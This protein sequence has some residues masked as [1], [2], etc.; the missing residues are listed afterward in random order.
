MI[1]PLIRLMRPGEW[2]KNGFVLPA[3]VVAL[4]TL[5]TDR[6]AVVGTHLSDLMLHTFLAFASFC[7]VSSGFYAI[8][9]V[10]DAASDRLHPV[11]KTR[12]VASG[13]V[14]PGVAL[15]FGIILIVA[16]FV[17]GAMVNRHLGMVL[18]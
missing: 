14:P 5:M 3:L 8:N 6:A 12:P 11:K 2:V 9:D 1:L 16:A 13:E 17:L 4:A 10:S 18:L 7:L 15:T